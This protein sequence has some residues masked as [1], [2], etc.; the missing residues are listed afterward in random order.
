MKRE[1]ELNQTV[2]TVE[3][4]PEVVNDWGTEVRYIEPKDGETFIE[5]MRRDHI[6]RGGVIYNMGKKVD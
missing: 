2:E 4:V 3:T 1:L 5:A 6:E